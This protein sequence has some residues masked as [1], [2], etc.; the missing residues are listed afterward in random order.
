MI[1]GEDVSR[2]ASMIAWICSTLLTL[3]A[4]TPYPPAAASSRSCRIDT[5]AIAA[6]PPCGLGPS[7]AGFGPRACRSR[8]RLG[9][10]EEVADARLL[11][12]FDG[13]LD[14]LI[15]LGVGAVDAR[16]DL[17]DGAGEVG[18]ILAEGGHAGREQVDQK[19]EIL[20][21]AQT[22][23]EEVAVHLL[24]LRR[25]R[26]YEV[27]ELAEPARGGVVVHRLLDRAL[28][29]LGQ[30]LL[31]RRRRLAQLSDVGLGAAQDRPQVGRRDPGLG[32]CRRNRCLPLGAG[33]VAK[34]LDAPVELG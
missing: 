15:E 18:D 29:R 26:A 24:D 28:D 23:C 10:A 4:P 12:A 17:A 32:R 6:E 16:A 13:H 19:L 14:G 22:L 30:R 27:A 31:K 25:E 1:T 3:N 34:L 33:P 2:A 11:G 20:D 5:I 7:L 8:L 21:P 9:R